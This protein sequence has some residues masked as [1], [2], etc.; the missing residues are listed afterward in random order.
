MGGYTVSL[1]DVV[2]TGQKVKDG[3]GVVFAPRGVESGARDD[4]GD[5]E[6][7]ESAKQGGIN[8][9]T[10]MLS[11]GDVLLPDLR[12]QFVARGMKVEYS[13]IKGG[14]QQLVVNG[15]IIIRKG[16]KLVE[17]VGG[18]ANV[19]IEGPLCEDYF[20]CRGVVYGQYVML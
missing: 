19:M 2:A 12:S 5:S 6:A 1:V 7:E 17:G 11:V 20:E 16:D 15:R 18:G 9:K 14:G 10:V 3:G 8:K 13:T 4:E